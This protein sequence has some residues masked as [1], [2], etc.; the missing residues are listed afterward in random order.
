[1]YLSSFAGDKICIEANKL[2][3][4]P[5]EKKITNINQREAQ[6][7][8]PKSD[9]RDMTNGIDKETIS[10]IC[11]ERYFSHNPDAIISKNIN[12][13]D[14]TLQTIKVE[15][16]PIEMFHKMCITKSS[17]SCPSATS[18]FANERNCEK[19]QSCSE[20]GKSNPKRMESTGQWVKSQT[21]FNNNNNKH[22]DKYI[23]RLP[24][25]RTSD[26][27]D[28]QLPKIIKE[29]CTKNFPSDSQGTYLHT[30]NRVDVVHRSL[31]TRN[32]M[33]YKQSRKYYAERT[34][35]I[36]S[37]QPREINRFRVLDRQPIHNKY[38]L[39]TVSQCRVNINSKPKLL[40][41]CRKDY[42]QQPMNRRIYEISNGHQRRAIKAR[43]ASPVRLKR[44]NTSTKSLFDPWVTLGICFCLD[45]D[46]DDSDSEDEETENAQTSRAKG[47]QKARDTSS[48]DDGGS[49]TD[50]DD[51]ISETDS[52]LGDSVASTPSAQ[53]GSDGGD[54]S[55]SGS[56]EFDGESF[57]SSAYEEE[58]MEIEDTMQGIGGFYDDD[59]DDDG[60]DRGIGDELGNESH[61]DSEDFYY[62][63]SDETTALYYGLDDVD[64]I[65]EE[66]QFDLYEIY[67]YF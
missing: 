52:K 30:H 65:A 44:S 15:L 2:W 47:T 22:I 9:G 12:K 43:S 23:W 39:N 64:T 29:L 26:A 54:D 21:D 58:V 7:V 38:P 66:D 1:M 35:Y 4:K 62:E 48:D 11:K 40:N 27:Q 59:N 37:L 8:L 28:N 17:E 57:A 6:H 36:S 50:L 24:K 55:D 25:E 18:S 34:R 33:L 13:H 14:R 46:S 45:N 42:I 5:Q 53:N 3:K 67:N 32:E 60:G 61:G 63:D 51:D 31:P 20:K 49:D 19:R 41:E 56:E 16:V 10:D